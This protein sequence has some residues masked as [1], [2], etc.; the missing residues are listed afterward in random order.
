MSCFLRAGLLLAVEVEVYGAGDFGG[1]LADPSALLQHAG[2][3]A[4][5]VGA[6]QAGGA[7]CAVYR[8]LTSGKETAK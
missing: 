4:H 8:R 3:D 5:E 7:A 6:G 2:V 1:G